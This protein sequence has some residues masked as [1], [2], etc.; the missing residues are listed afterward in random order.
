MNF[1][2][3]QFA[4]DL[5]STIHVRLTNRP[6]SEHEQAGVRIL[7]III[8]IA[9]IHIV[10]SI[11][12]SLPDV[13]I[14]SIYL[15]Y[16]ILVFSLTVFFAI[17]IHPQKSTLRR[18]IGIIY[19][20]TII[21][22]FLYLWGDLAAPW[23]GVYLWVVF[24]NGFRYGEKYL[25]L[26]AALSII[27]FSLVLLFTPF[28]HGIMPLGI[29][30]LI[31]LFV[32]PGYVVTLIKRIQK[33]KDKAEQANQAKSEFLARMSHEIRTPLNGIIGT[34]ELLETSELNSEDREYVATIKSSGESLLKLIEDVLD[35]SKI[36]AGKMSTE[37]LDFDLYNLITSTMNIFAP[38]ARNKGLALYR[39]IDIRLPIL[40]KGDPTHIRQVLINLLG[41]AIKFTES[42][43]ISLNCFPVDNK[44]S[45]VRFE[46]VD[47]GIGINR[48]I[49]DTIFTKF[50]QADEGTT[51]N[52]GGSGLGTTIAKQL[53]ELMGG[54][55]GV[56]SSP[57]QGSTFWFELPICN[58]S[59]SG[60]QTE[61][62][63]FSDI[64]VL[65]I[66][67][68]QSNQ[69]NAT[70]LLKRWKVGLIEVDSITQA[71]ETLE[72]TSNNIDIILLDGL[73]ATDDIIN[74]LLPTT[75]SSKHIIVFIQPEHD[76]I[77]QETTCRPSIYNLLEPLES[78]QLL[79][80]MH[81]AQTTKLLSGPTLSKTINPPNTKQLKILAVE[82][83]PINQM[84]LERILK[85]NGHKL[86]MVSNG[87]LALEALEA[88]LYDLVILDMHMPKLGGIDTYKKYS[89]ISNDHQTPFIMLTANA[90]VDARMQCE[91]AGIK[92]FLTKP[93]SSTSLLY[94]INLATGN[95][96]ITER[97][98][99]N[100]EEITENRV[101]KSID[102]AILNRVISMAPDGE[103]LNRLHQSMDSYG[104]SILNGMNQAI[105]D[106]D[107]QKFRDLAH[108]LR[109]ATMSLGM[110]ELSQLLEQAESIT[111]GRF[112]KHGVVHTA[113]LSRAFK[114]GMSQT[115][116]EFKDAENC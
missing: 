31:S 13:V 37:S 111:S 90:T 88:E 65:R 102:T 15:L 106:E 59:S 114:Q 52:Y 72:E 34:G 8:S 109:G 75:N 38:Q 74:L 25:Y 113:K 92:H 87:E 11:Y 96:E 66:S 5:W 81:L 103:F 16:A 4:T 83:N 41:N 79:K 95:E 56:T 54:E 108:T 39:N 47:T 24:G 27:S 60:Q 97:L 99:H 49:Q 57:G 50:T 3:A 76:N 28:W 9:Y 80:T 67:N 84:V 55:I 70:N 63:T 77:K 61:E 110:S 35:I 64:N 58:P 68:N 82:D 7:I 112:K 32:L 71:K 86:K 10:D 48:E 101:T 2:P 45:S 1:W 40:A 85:N 12:Q 22:M 98:N 115:R 21:G 33:E 36:E 19:D 105:R 42:G 89:A 29:G 100:E 91:Q 104:K 44:P 107:L 78:K 18:I 93:I 69:T 43:S 20:P 51:R 17:L 53:V 26:S 46:V 14:S 116:K 94:A 6:D 62:A 30:L 73:S 23:Y